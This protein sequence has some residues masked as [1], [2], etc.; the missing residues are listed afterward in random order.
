MKYSKYKKKRGGVPNNPNNPNNTVASSI[1]N[2]S[3]VLEKK[4]ME[5]L[6][7]AKNTTTNAIISSKNAINNTRSALGNYA[8]NFTNNAKNFTNNAKI[9]FSNVANNTRKKISEI[10]NKLMGNSN[11]TAP[12]QAK[13]GKT[14]KINNTYK[15]KK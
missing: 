4:S 13:G 15:I 1:F 10:Y 2:D 12:T 9:Y 14:K 8:T 7:S 6:T 5:L 11:T 3:A